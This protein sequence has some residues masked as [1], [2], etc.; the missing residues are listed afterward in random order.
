LM[1]T[2]TS[3]SPNRNWRINSVLSNPSISECK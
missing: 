3:N 2:K 1:P